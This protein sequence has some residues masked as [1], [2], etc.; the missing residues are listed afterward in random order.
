MDLA[1]PSSIFN[2]SVLKAV[3]GWRYKP[4]MEE[5]VPVATFNVRDRVRFTLER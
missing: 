1:V 4:R 5:G 3:K 2:R